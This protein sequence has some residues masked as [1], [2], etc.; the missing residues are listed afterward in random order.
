MA[1]LAWAV[2]TFG[3]GLFYFVKT[4]KRLAELI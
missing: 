3:L 1:A 4:E 2:G